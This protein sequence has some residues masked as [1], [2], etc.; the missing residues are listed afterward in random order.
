MNLNKYTFEV[1]SW[2][3]KK[4]SRKL[5]DQYHYASGN[6]HTIIRIDKSMKLTS[7]NFIFKFKPVLIYCS[8]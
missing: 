7:T 2:I 8:L 1:S 5:I 3:L 4:L 6:N